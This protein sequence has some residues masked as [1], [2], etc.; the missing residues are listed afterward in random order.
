MGP[1]KIGSAR[2]SRPVATRDAFIT[3]QQ[4]QLL[5]PF[6]NGSNIAFGI[7][8][9]Q[10]RYLAVNP[11]LAATNRLPPEHH[12]K[13]TVRDVMGEVAPAVESTF[14]R[15]MVTGKPVLRE[16]GGK[17]PT[18]SEGVHWI[19]NYFPVKDTDGKV[20]RVGAIVVEVTEQKA[21]QRSLR[22]LAQELPGQGIK[23][24]RRVAQ[25]LHQSIVRYHSA[26]KRTLNLLIRPIWQIE[27]RAALLGQ[28]AELLQH[29]PVI[30][31]DS[32]VTVRAL[33]QEFEH[34]PKLR[35]RLFT[36]IANQ[37]ELQRDLLQVVAK[38]PGVRD[39]LMNE[40]ATNLKF[41]SWLL[42]VA[43]RSV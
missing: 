20:R 34:D 1:R 30:R 4:Q 14:E 5:E 33:F 35:N 9:T 32:P 17:T 25:E 29:F 31:F 26:L 18:R 23:E 43:G 7:C 11:A 42:G 2:E 21:L 15:V 22:I 12:L 16:V 10:L 13:N 36:R 28:S 27:D 19:G 6:L 41:R 38:H 3:S 24:Q 37:P 8:D 39:D 40:L